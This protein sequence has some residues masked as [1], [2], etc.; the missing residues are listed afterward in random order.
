[1]LVFVFLLVLKIFVNLLGGIKTVKITKIISKKF[2]DIVLTLHVGKVI[3]EVQFTK[4]YQ[5]TLQ[6]I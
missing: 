5:S 4:M 1:M 3:F 2:T 6:D